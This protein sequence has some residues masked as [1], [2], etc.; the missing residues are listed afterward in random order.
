[1][2]RNLLP[3]LFAI[4][5]VLLGACLL[6]FFWETVRWRAPMFGAVPG[7]GDGSWRSLHMHALQFWKNWQHEGMARSR[8]ILH[9]NPF[10]IERESMTSYYVSYP[11]GFLFLPFFLSKFLGVPPSLEGLMTLSLA[12]HLACALAAACVVYYFLRR[13]LCI[14]G[15]TAVSLGFCAGLA[16]LLHPAALLWFQN[17]WWPDTAV[18]PLLLAALFWELWRIN[19]PELRGRALLLGET[20]L[21]LAGCLT[22]WLFFLYLGCVFLVRKRRGLL[23]RA[24]YWKGLAAA[25]ALALLYH[26]YVLH[27]TAGFGIFFLKLKERTGISPPPEGVGS[28]LSA[29]DQS[30]GSAG[31]YIYFAMIPVSLLSLAILFLRR[32]KLSG[33]LRLHEL[34][35]LA[36]LP[37]FLHNLI[38]YEHYSIHPYN[39]LKFATLFAL[40]PFNTLPA[41]LFS[42]L[43]PGSERALFFRNLTLFL[44]AFLSLDSY[45]HLNRNTFSTYAVGLASEKKNLVDACRFISRR[46]SY[47]DLYFSPDL[48]VTMGADATGTDTPDNHPM[49]VPVCD[50]LVRK[51]DTIA[52]LR[53]LALIMHRRDP[54]NMVPERYRLNM[55]FLKTVKKYWLP[56]LDMTHAIQEKDYWIVPLKAGAEL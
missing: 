42:R 39:T 12:A 11:P 44:V 17:T 38:V 49:L 7:L 30:T 6:W 33:S 20:L 2:K 35:V 54:K 10:S 19:H 23:R 40:F 26:L 16:Q 36:G 47:T 25:P 24:E 1:M 13:T 18:L 37:F 21:F 43:K 48:S 29:L 46:R 5:C 4:Y 34:C 9:F 51:V 41:W 56:Y 50:K 8:F 53:R 45:L 14:D 55:F 27:R 31:I 15:V 3:A 32:E 22:D 52:D 28:W